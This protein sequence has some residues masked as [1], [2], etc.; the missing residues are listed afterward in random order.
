MY[1]LLNLKKNLIAGLVLSGSV[2][3]A[4]AASSLTKSGVEYPIMPSLARDQVLPHLGLGPNGGY[5]VA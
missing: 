3:V 5:I 2:A 4:G 1:S